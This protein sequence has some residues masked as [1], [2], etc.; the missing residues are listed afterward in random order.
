[1]ERSRAHDGDQ[2][3]RAD[4]GARRLGAYEAACRR[5]LRGPPRARVLGQLPPAPRAGAY[6]RL[7][8]IAR[9]RGAGPRRHR[10]ASAG[11]RRWPRGRTRCCRTSARPRQLHGRA[12]ETVDAGDD[13][14]AR[15]ALAAARELVERGAAARG[16]HR[17]GGGGARWTAAPSGSPRRS[18]G[19]QPDRRGRRVRAG[20]G[21]GARARRG[22]RAAGARASPRGRV[23]GDQLAGDL[24]PAR[25]AELAVGLTARVGG[26]PR[27]YS[28]PR[29]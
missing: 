25:A 14:A 12:E 18:P 1:M 2:R 3:A 22:V 16:R 17:R 7:V 26:A 19:P 11:R 23:G 27:A 13:A 10:R 24:D 9:A 5:A 20:L 4:A 15:A 28:V 29:E 6:G 21:A 8:E